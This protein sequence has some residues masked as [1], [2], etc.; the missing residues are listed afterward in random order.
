MSLDAL[1]DHVVVL[2]G[3]V[4][5]AARAFLAVDRVGEVVEGARVGPRAE[6]LEQLVRERGADVPPRAHLRAGLPDLLQLVDGQAGRPVVGGVD[7]DGQRV[8]RDLE[9]D[10]LH[11]VLLADRDLLLVDRARCVRQ[12]GLAAA[13]A[14]EP[15]ARPEMP[16]VTST[17]LSSRNPSAADVTYGPTVLDPSAETAPPSDPVRS[18]AGRDADRKRHEQE[19]GHTSASVIAS[20]SFR[21]RGECSVPTSCTW[22]TGW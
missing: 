19:A 21:C 11:A 14:L 8:V 3:L 5:R 1:D 16:T 20:P 10:V 15:A 6:E 17:P 4:V 18:A 2:R 22:A 13:E 12:V 9:L 7:D